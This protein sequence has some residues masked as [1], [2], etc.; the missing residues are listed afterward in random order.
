MIVSRLECNGRISAHGNFC[1]PGSSDSPASPS[2][3]AGITST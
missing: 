3:V 2:R 1:L